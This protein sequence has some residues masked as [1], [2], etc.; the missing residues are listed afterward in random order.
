MRPCLYNKSFSKT[1]RKLKFLSLLVCG[2]FRARFLARF[3]WILPAEKL[4]SDSV[5]G[6]EVVIHSQNGEEVWSRRR[7]LLVRLVR[8]QHNGDGIVNAANDRPLNNHKDPAEMKTKQ[9][10]SKK[11]QN[12]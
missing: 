4:W 7:A 11:T 2:K 5:F 12:K 6:Q 3:S 1:S 8:E 9:I 10:I